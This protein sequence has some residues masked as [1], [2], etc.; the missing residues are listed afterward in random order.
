MGQQKPGET[1]LVG[2]HFRI[3]PDLSLKIKLA[4]L[5]EGITQKT[6]ITRIF[7]GYFEDHPIDVSR[8][9]GIAQN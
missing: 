6:L 9:P 1:D 3:E 5:S 4:A 2:L 7:S 8:L